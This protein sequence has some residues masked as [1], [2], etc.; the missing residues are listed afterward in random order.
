M[1]TGVAKRSVGRIVGI[2]SHG[3]QTYYGNTVQ[4]PPSHCRWLI[5]FANIPPLPDGQTYTLSVRRA[6]GEL[7]GNVEYLKVD[8]PTKGP[9]I[10]FPNSGNLDHCSFNFV[11]YGV[12]DRP[13]ANATVRRASGGDP[14]DADFIYED[15]GTGFWS[16]TF[17]GLDDADDYIFLIEDIDS[18]AADVDDLRIMEAFC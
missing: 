13:I 5:H 9:I 17:P 7:V 10:Y 8:P 4:G 16:A 15:P 1:A 12:T 14:I 11:A 3:D 2:L 18:G 6:S